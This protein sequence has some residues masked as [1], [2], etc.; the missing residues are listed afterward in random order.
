MLKDQT[1]FEVI[2]NGPMQQG[3]CLLTVRNKTFRIY[4]R[5]MNVD[6]DYNTGIPEIALQIRT[7]DD[8]TLLANALLTEEDE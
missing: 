5:H 7:F 6:I 1:L 8:C 4:I 3:E 2:K